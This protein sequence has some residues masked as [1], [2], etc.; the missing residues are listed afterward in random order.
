[1]GAYRREMLKVDPVAYTLDS[2]D[3]V[4]YR[5][6]RPNFYFY[7]LWHIIVWRYFSL[8]FLGRCYG[9]RAS[10]I[11]LS[12]K[13]LQALITA[14]SPRDPFDLSF[15]SFLLRLSQSAGSTGEL[16]MDLSCF[17]FLFTELFLYS[18]EGTGEECAL[19]LCQGW[20]SRHVTTYGHD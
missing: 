14:G 17:M 12:L 3:T 13:L 16:T 2:V 7:D 11:T 19:F 15:L 10:S 20:S 6:L 18:V 1:M 4:T 5:T 9:C 8:I